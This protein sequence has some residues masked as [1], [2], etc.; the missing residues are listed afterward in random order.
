MKTLKEKIAVMQAAAEGK[1]IQSRFCESD[2][3]TNDDT[4]IFNWQSFDYRV[5]PEPEPKRY[6]PYTLEELKGIIGKTVMSKD[7]STHGIITG[8]ANFNSD[9]LM[10]VG[11]FG[12]YVNM[13]LEKFVHLDGTPCG[14]EEGGEE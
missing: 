7:E 14:V 10:S 8:V 12:F 5:K 6:R 9:I 1:N 2:D 13:F 11:S 4:G 3:Y